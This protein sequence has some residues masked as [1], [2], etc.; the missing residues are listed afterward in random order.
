[1][2]RDRDP[3]HLFL[4]LERDNDR[5]SRRG[6]FFRV[7]EEIGHDLYQMVRIDVGL[8]IERTI[9][10]ADFYIVAGGIARIRL[11]RLSQDRRKR[12]AAK[13]KFQAA[14]LDLLDIEYV[15]DEP[16]EPLAI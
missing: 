10:E 15:V 12:L 16:D 13:P 8:R 9:L 2:V 4:T 3:E 5:I 7:G 6:E 1:M 14:G 11:D